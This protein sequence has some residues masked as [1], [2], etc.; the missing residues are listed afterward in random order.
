M[1]KF[2]NFGRSHSVTN[3]TSRAESGK[4]RFL[5]INHLRKLVTNYLSISKKDSL[6]LNITSKMAIYSSSKRVKLTDYV[7]SES[8]KYKKK[9]QETD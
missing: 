7:H 8:E 2:W 5:S 6:E 3:I 4:K 1:N 9:T